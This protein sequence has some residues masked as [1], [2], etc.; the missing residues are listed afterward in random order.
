MDVPDIG[1]KLSPDLSLEKRVEGGSTEDEWAEANGVLPIARR[2]PEG[3]DSDSRNGSE[4]S[5]GS[6][7]GEC[8]DV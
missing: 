5:K 8:R 4:E 3:K 2:E 1:L 6:P 7:L